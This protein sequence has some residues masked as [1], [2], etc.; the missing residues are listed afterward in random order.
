M[1]E[2]RYTREFDVDGNELDSI[3]YEV[4]DEELQ[5]EAD[6]VRLC[7]ICEMGHSAMPV[8]VLAEGFILLCKRLGFDK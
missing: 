1:P 5:L 4:S 6:E 3:P 2:I 7:E 8:P